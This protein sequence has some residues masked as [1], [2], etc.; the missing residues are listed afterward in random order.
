MKHLKFRKA[1]SILTALCLLGSAFFVCAA[2]ED[3]QNFLN[4][5]KLT[6][7]ADGAIYRCT[8]PNG[9]ELYFVADA[10][11][12]PVVQMEDVNFDGT[13]DV[14]AL[15]RL[16]AS[17]AYYDLYVW[18]GEQYVYATPYGGLANYTL[19]ADK[20][21][22]VS[23]ANNGLAGMECEVCIY[24]WEGAELTAVR[25]LRSE[26]KSEW[27]DST[28]GSYSF[29]IVYDNR[30]LHAAVTDYTADIYEGNV[31]WEKDFNMEADGFDDRQVWDEM[32]DALTAGL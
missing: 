23:H 10:S 9:Q 22:V 2:A 27:Q 11:Q 31:I 25:T 20:G 29:A 26:T 30:I 21:Y 24:R 16:G 14:V 28:D 19:D 5:E 3:K 32:H 18:D 15:T 1:L 4:F 7:A 13:D 6:D 8:A 12:E 17:N